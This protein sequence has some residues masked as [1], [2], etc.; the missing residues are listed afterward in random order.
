MTA[1]GLAA[2]GRCS[3]RSTRCT[4]G[5]IAIHLPKQP[6]ARYR[7]GALASHA[8]P[9]QEIVSVVRNA[10][11]LGVDPDNARAWLQS[12]SVAAPTARCAIASAAPHPRPHRRQ[13]GTLDRDRDPGI[14]DINP[15]RPLRSR[16]SPTATHR[17]RGDRKAHEQVIAEIAS[18]SKTAPVLPPAPGP[19]QPPPAPGSRRPRPDRLRA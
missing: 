2:R 3:S 10:G 18:V 6:I 13:D 5:S 4:R 14:L 16:S 9:P 11:G 12:L 19:S 7:L 17:S 15:Q 1:A 8:D